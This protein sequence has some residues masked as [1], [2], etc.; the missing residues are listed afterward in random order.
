MLAPSP[1][2]APTD[3]AVGV[4]P[5]GVQRQIPELTV[6]RVRAAE[7]GKKAEEKAVAPKS[8][9]PKKKRK[10]S[11]CAIAECKSIDGAV[12]KVMRRKDGPRGRS[13]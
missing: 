5:D 1:D 10:E 3:A 2:A 4:W 7:K 13:G 11:T 8:H 6:E 9:P 12:L